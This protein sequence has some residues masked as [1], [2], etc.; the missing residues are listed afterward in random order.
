MF[1][2]GIDS[3]SL[4]KLMKKTNINSKFTAL[5]EIKQKLIKGG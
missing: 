2:I 4:K 3:K 1:R 5:S